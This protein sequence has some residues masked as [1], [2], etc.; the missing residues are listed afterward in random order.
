MPSPEEVFEPVVGNW[1]TSTKRNAEEKERLRT[2]AT[3]VIRAFTRDEFKNA[4]AVAEVV[5]LA[6]VL[7]K[8][9]FRSLLM[10]FVNGVDKS[11]LLDVQSLEGLA[12]L[13]Q[14]AP[15][16][17]LDSDDLAA[18]LRNL[19]TRLQDTHTQSSDHIQ[20]PYVRSVQRP[21]CHGRYQ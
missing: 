5:C 4:K 16:G 7:E 18:I 20:P 17:Y 11:S 21:G 15:E 19:N 13:V 6:P 12:Q 9:Y 2:M 3:D 8:K 10:L 14:S 1:V